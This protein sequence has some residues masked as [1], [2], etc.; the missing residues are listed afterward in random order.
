MI[1][2]YKSNLLLF[3]AHK[4]RTQMP[5]GVLYFCIYKGRL[6]GGGGEGY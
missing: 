4:C 3:H 5:Q 1:I 6:E 2:S